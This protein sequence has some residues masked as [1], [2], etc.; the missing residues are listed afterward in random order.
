M[1]GKWSPRDLAVRWGLDQLA[2]TRSS[3]RAAASARYFV[4]GYRYGN[5]LPAPASSLPAEPESIGDLERYAN[6]YETGP[7]LN[8]WQHYLEIY[9]RHLGRFRGRP[10]HIVEVGI[11]A[12]GSLGMW[13]AFLG[14]D[15]QVYGVDI[16]PDCRKHEGDGVRVFIGDQADPGFWSRFLDE[17]PQIDIVI[18]DGGHH[19]EQQIATLE[20]LLPHVSPGGVYVTEDIHGPFQPFHSYVD[21]LSRPLHDIGHQTQPNPTSAFQQQVASVHRYPLLTVIE[22]PA[23]ARPSFESPVRGT[24]WPESAAHLGGQ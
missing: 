15:I 18:E 7:G 17:V 13:R 21:G 2:I 19:P 4:Q 11:F 16:D 5:R 14:S 9:D 12:G 24:E 8:K 22:K 6:A 23:Y 1:A 3:Y 10:L 20:A